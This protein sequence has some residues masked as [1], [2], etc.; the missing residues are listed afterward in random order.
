VWTVVG[1]A[2]W[3]WDSSLSPPSYSGFEGAYE[4]GCCGRSNYNGHVNLCM[5]IQK[6]TKSLSFASV[7]RFDLQIKEAKYPND[8]YTPSVSTNT[9]SIHPFLMFVL[10]RSASFYCSLVTSD[11]FKQIRVLKID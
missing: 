2:L 8:P 7:L 5:P 10:F 11:V 9:P 6:E 1:V 4:C 3:G